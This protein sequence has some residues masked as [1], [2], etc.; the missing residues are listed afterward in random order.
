MWGDDRA[1]FASLKT[2]RPVAAV[3]TRLYSGWSYVS[4]RLD[5]EVVAYEESGA[6]FCFFVSC[7]I[8]TVY[9]GRFILGLVC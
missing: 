2:N 7:A 3:V 1:T 5:A 9:C 8:T 4:V 6:F